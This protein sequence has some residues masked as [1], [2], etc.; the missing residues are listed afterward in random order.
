[1]SQEFVTRLLDIPK[2]F[3][4]DFLIKKIADEFAPRIISRAGVSPLIKEERERERER[5]RKRE[6]R[7]VVTYF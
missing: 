2:L 3:V 4:R 1:L 6:T 5:E 7:N